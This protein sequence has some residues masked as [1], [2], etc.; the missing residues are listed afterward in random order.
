M[1]LLQQFECEKAVCIYCTHNL[2]ILKNSK[3]SH[4]NACQNDVYSLLHHRKL[5]QPHF[6]R[7]NLCL[8]YNYLL[9]IKLCIKSPYNLGGGMGTVS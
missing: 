7:F 1:K 6:T 3:D 4:A 2:S 9:Y 5:A 8:K